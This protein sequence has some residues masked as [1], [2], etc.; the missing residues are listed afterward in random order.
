MSAL[1]QVLLAADPEVR[2]MRAGD[3]PPLGHDPL[4]RLWRDAVCR[5][6]YSLPIRTV[7]MLTIL[8]NVIVFLLILVLTWLGVAGLVFLMDWLWSSEP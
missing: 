4:P 6:R 3:E 2:G 1:S 5:D 7:L 8:H